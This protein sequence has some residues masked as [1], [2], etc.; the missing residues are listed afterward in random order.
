LQPSIPII[1]YSSTFEPI[2]LPVATLIITHDTAL[3]DVADSI[4]LW[5]TLPAR[6]GGMKGCKL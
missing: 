2:W 1:D 3:Q 4:I 6:D 5:F